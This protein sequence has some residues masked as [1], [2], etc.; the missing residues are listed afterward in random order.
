MDTNSQKEDRRIVLELIL[1]TRNT[2]KTREF[3]ELLGHDFDVIDLSSFPQITMPAESGRTF[4]EN[5]ILKAIGTSRSDV[6]TAQRAVPTFVIA[7]DSGLEVDALEGAPGVYSA[8]YAGENATNNDNID[9]LLSE[10]RARNVANDKC[11]A[12]FRCVIALAKEG[13][14]LGTFEGTVEGIVVDPPRGSGGFGYDPIFQPNGFKQTFAEISPELKNKISHR[15]KAIAALRE[16]FP[17]F[18]N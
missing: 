12:R 18:E 10:L 17:S 7:D 6:R 1:A 14:L 13:K 4:T 2:H 16:A 11:S 3:R 9:K 15:G 5:A 8:R